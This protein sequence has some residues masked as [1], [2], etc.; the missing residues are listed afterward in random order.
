MQHDP[1]CFNH[2]LF[3]LTNHSLSFVNHSLSGLT[4]PSLSVLIARYP[5]LSV[6]LLPGTIE[7][8][9]D[10]EERRGSG[11]LS[12]QVDRVRNRELDRAS[13]EWW[14]GL[15][16]HRYLVVAVGIEA[17]SRGVEARRE[18]RAGGAEPGGM[19]WIGSGEGED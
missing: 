18:E 10:D 5:S 6:G 3:V 17:H 11:P 7:P 4:S 12:R 19:G 13:I 2:S 1:P 8:R 9:A 16:G 15:N 14:V